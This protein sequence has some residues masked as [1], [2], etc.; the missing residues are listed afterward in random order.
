[1]LKYRQMQQTIRFGSYTIDPDRL[2]LRKHNVRIKLQRQPFKLLLLLIARRGSVVGRD[3]MI[4][5]LWGDGT[6]VDFDRSLNF[7]VSQIRTALGDD[8][9]SPKYVETVHREG[10][11]F[12]GEVDPAEAVAEPEPAPTVPVAPNRR[13]FLMYAAA[14]IAGAAGAGLLL[15]RFLSRQR[16]KPNTPAAFTGLAGRLGGPAFSPDG[17]QVAFS[18]M[19]EDRLSRAEIHVKLV[20]SAETLQLTSGEALDEFPVWA[21]D[22]KSIYFSRE[23][24]AEAGIWQVPAL[25][26]AAKRIAP[27]GTAPLYGFKYRRPFDILPGGGFL[28]SFHEAGRGWVILRIMANGEKVAALTAPPNGSYDHNP[29]VSPDGKSFVFVRSVGGD[30]KEL[31]VQPLSGGESA[32]LVR[33]T[34]VHS[35]TWTP[36]GK[37]VLYCASV[38]GAH[39]IWLVP[40][41]GG[42]P[43]LMQGA[44]ARLQ[45]I[46]LSPTGGIA[47]YTEENPRIDLWRAPLRDAGEP[48]RLIVSGRVHDSPRF[49]PDGKRLA[50]YSNR[51]GPMQVWIAD[52]NGGGAHPLTNGLYPDWSPDGKRLAYLFQGGIHTIAA[53]G[54]QAET[55]WNAGRNFVTRPV[56][57]PDG[58]WIYFESNLHGGIDIYKLPAK[59]GAVAPVRVTQSGGIRP[60]IYDGFLYF[61][62]R[63][64]GT[65]RVSLNGGAEERMGQSS[66]AHTAM[67]D[68]LYVLTADWRLL[69]IDYRTKAVMEIRRLEKATNGSS[70]AISPDEG[71]VVYAYQADAGH[72]IMLVRDF[73][74]R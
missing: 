59:P 22:G 74:W 71:Q 28:A 32:P 30:P 13:R 62:K 66:I 67:P 42:E 9:A 3:E 18:W 40:A 47:A 26:G 25:G 19:K 33:A 61:L 14:G 37:S 43:R 21:A 54:G 60:Q 65:M 55:V 48:R 1:M 7:C 58:N 73:D 10:Y 38:Q 16:P 36:D 29:T 23:L 46:T 12:V 70:I 11:R 34:W 8:S 51:A 49:S 27:L 4:Q 64:T 15:N 56:W 35:A 72:E 52:A 45:D 44:G 53:D 57:S 50:Y 17:R 41:S 31:R 24:G 6:Q 2:I 39:G 69:R 63:Q 68:G 5:E 20:G